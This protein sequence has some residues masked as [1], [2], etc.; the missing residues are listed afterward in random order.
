MEMVL[1]EM[2][3]GKISM[4]SM[5]C[6]QRAKQAR[7]CQRTTLL[8]CAFVARSREEIQQQSQILAKERMHY[9][10]PLHESAASA[11]ACSSL[12]LF[13]PKSSFSSVIMI[14]VFSFCLSGQGHGFQLSSEQVQKPRWVDLPS[15]SEFTDKSIISPRSAFP[16][17]YNP[18]NCISYLY[19][20]VSCSGR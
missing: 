19:G 8:H 4:G 3:V 2:I 15:G 9:F 20:M 18:C 7:D 11:L 14:Q 16:F 1:A 12:E 13:D 10:N 17:P 5:L 6:K